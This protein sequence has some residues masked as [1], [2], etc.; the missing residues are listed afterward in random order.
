MLK[1]SY[2]GYKMFYKVYK[3]K[4]EVV[5]HIMDGGLDYSA[6]AP[7]EHGATNYSESQVFEDVYHLSMPDLEDP[8][9]YRPEFNEV[10]GQYE[11]V[12]DLA[13]QASVQASDALKLD[14]ESKRSLRLDKLRLAYDNMDAVVADPVK[15]RKLLKQM[16]ISIAR[17]S[18]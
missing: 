14:Q 4:N 10:L 6:S 8:R 11:L 7:K 15:L 12:K 9:F 1:L 3:I 2:K 13:L 5:T 16:L 18:E 17:L